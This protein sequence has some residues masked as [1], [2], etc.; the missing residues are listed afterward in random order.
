MSLKRHTGRRETEYKNEIFCL[1]DN[2]A[3]VLSAVYCLG[4][5]NFFVDT[6]KITA[7]SMYAHKQNNDTHRKLAY[8]RGYYD[9]YRDRKQIRW[10]TSIGI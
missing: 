4:N 9:G 7:G 8:S 2:Y 6:Y 1:T 10:K 5:K 3:L